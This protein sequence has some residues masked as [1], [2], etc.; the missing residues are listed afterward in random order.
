MAGPQVGI[1]PPVISTL[2]LD[3]LGSPG[4]GPRQTCGRHG[5][6]GTG[7]GEPQEIDSWDKFCE[8][9]A[10][11]GIE[12]VR[13]CGDRSI[14]LDRLDDRLDHSLR[15][16]TE[17]QGTIA[18]AVVDVLVAIDVPE[19]GALTVIEAEFQTLLQPCVGTLATCDRSTDPL[20]KLPALGE[21]RIAQQTIGIHTTPPVSNRW[22]HGHGGSHARAYPA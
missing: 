2:H 14:A 11:F 21:I 17:D 18:E 15:L 6:L 3:D 16:V 7:V 9:L 12:F 10:D 13:E 8:Q 22:L 20:E 1:G 4:I 19:V 5:R